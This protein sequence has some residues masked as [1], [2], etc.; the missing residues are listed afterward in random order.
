M[1]DSVSEHLFISTL[2]TEIN[3]LKIQNDILLSKV[4][5]KDEEINILQKSITRYRNLVQG[6][7]KK[8]KHKKKKKTKLIKKEYSVKDEIIPKQLRS[9]LSP[10]IKY[11]LH[12]KESRKVHSKKKFESI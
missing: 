3:D 1:S 12:D 11:P 7:D 8:T 10:A 2:K 5:Q 4:K 9:N 6:K